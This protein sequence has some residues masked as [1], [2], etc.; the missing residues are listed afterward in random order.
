MRAKRLF[1][2]VL[3]CLL[4]IALLPSS[5]FAAEKK[6]P[7]P[8]EL[9]F[10]NG[11]CAFE[12][13]AR[14]K[15]IDQQ[16]AGYKVYVGY[17]TPASSEY[18]TAIYFDG[19]P[20]DI[21][22]WNAGLTMPDHDVLIEVVTESRSAYTIDLTA[23]SCMVP[24][25]VYAYNR[26]FGDSSSLPTGTKNYDLNGS[27]KNDITVT[28]NIGDPNA[29][30]Q[31]HAD[32]DIDYK[33]VEN[34]SEPNTPIKS[35]TYIFNEEPTPT[36]VPTATP[37]PTPA[38]TISATPA[39]TPAATPTTA[40]TPT[41]T[42]SPVKV[43]FD[44]NGHGTAPEPQD[45]KQGDKVKRP[46]DP[47]E[48][49][50]TFFAWCTDPECTKMYDFNKHVTK[51]FTLYAKWVEEINISS[52]FT[53]TFNTNG[54]GT[55]PDPQV[56]VPGMKASEPANPH[57]DGFVFD[58]WYTDAM[59]IVPFDFDSEISQDITLYAKWTPEGAVGQTESTEPTET[60]EEPDPT[61]KSSSKKKKKSKTEASGNSILKWIWIP[62]VVVAVAGAGTVIFLL[63]KKN[64]KQK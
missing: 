10:V 45:L 60:T 8:Y 2:F 5:V 37:T 16:W 59:C 48:D 47:K 39:P 34:I 30:Y 53:V 33:Y 64:K 32:C 44:A 21:V 25:Q 31:K 28:W 29:F 12:D 51:D 56:L 61:S 24:M 43:T 15:Y 54:H 36:P 26:P 9:T 14:I 50:F 23:G 7:V 63:V 46:E 41:P 18:V 1:S 22:D 27:G 4:G 17:S 58:G 3:S 20:V 38:P 11:A 49:G 35:F 19:I 6:A 62:I 52:Y 55:A 42:P 57:E 40:A 13:S